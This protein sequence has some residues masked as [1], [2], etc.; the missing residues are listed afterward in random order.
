[1][2]DQCGNELGKSSFVEKK[3]NRES[4]KL[5]RKLRIGGKE[6]RDACFIS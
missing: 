5:F 1:M 3:K 4:G 6:R 2:K